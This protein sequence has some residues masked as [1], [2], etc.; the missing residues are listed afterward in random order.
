MAGEGYNKPGFYIPDGGPEVTP[1]MGK[2]AASQTW[3]RG[4]MLAR[5][6]GQ[7]IIATATSA[8]LAGPAADDRTSTS[9]NDLVPFYGKPDQEFVGI[10]D[11]NATAVEAGA[12]VDIV[13]T[14]GAMMIDIGA[15]S[16]DVITFGR[17]LADQT[18]TAQYAKALC[19]IT[20]GKHTEQ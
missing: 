11:A 16:Y 2:A 13:G 8:A 5:S 18:V 1:D 17:I 10:V 4:D 6:S 20:H 9:A 7:L 15:S 19:R 14:T 12:L 3:A